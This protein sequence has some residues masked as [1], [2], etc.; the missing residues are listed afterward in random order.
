MRVALVT[1]AYDKQQGMGRCVAELAERLARSH[2]VHIFAPSW[3]TRGAVAVEVHPVP[4]VFRRWYLMVPAFFLSSGRLLKRHRFDVVHLHVPSHHHAHVVTCH[5]VPR[6][7]IEYL[8]G[9]PAEAGMELPLRQ[10]L[11]HGLLRSV[12]AYNF[13]RGRQGRAIAVSSQVREELVKFYGAAPQKITVIPNGVDVETFHPR[14]REVWAR[15]VRAQYGLPEDS[16]VFLLVGHDLRLKGLQFVLKALGLLRARNV[17]LL[18]VGGPGR[19]TSYFARMVEAL[20][21]MNPPV[22]AGF[23]EEVWKFYAAADCFVFPSLYEAFPLVLLE[24]MASGLPVITAKTMGG[25]ADVVEDGVS[26]LLVDQPWDVERL[27]A[28]MDLVLGDKDLRGELGGRARAVAERYSWDRNAERTLRA[29]AE[30][31]G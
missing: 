31:L 20:G 10:A 17:W 18:V 23:Q 28:R 7:G 14:Q 2:E 12:F 1:W 29:Y 24:A 25:A 8:R 16:F 26:G 5:S 13:R 3:A 4:V 30:V 27:A 19:D 11:P 22:F 15:R 6:A 21:L 9:L